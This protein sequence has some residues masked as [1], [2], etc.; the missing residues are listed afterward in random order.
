MSDALTIVELRKELGLSQEGFAEQVGLRSKGHLSQIER[1]N[2]TPSVRVALEIERLSGGRIPAASLNADV[3]L[4][5]TFRAEAANEPG[6][7]PE[8]VSA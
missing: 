6:C 7:T 4:V 5:D 2:E 1:G 8:A 3:A